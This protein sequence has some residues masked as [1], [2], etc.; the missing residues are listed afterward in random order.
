MFE[1]AQDETHRLRLRG[2]LRQIVESIWVLVVPPA[3]HRL[4][5]VQIFFAGG[6]RRDYL[7]HYWSAGNVREGGWEVKTID[8]ATIDSA[9]AVG[10]KKRGSK[11]VSAMDHDLRIQ[12]DVNQLDKKLATADL[13]KLF[14]R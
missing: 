13:Q 11:P 5:A 8:S 4:A 2:L 6:T 3:S 7:I 1:I 9:S 10:G 14:V 12:E